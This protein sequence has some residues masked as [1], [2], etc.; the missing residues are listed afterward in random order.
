MASDVERVAL[1]AVSASDFMLRMIEQLDGENLVE[2]AM[3]VWRLWKDRNNKV[4]NGRTVEARS[5]VFFTQKFYA[6]WA[7]LRGQASSAPRV[8]FCPAWHRPPVGCIKLNVDGAFFANTHEMWFG[9]VL[10]DSHGRHICSR[11]LLLPELYSS[12]EGEAIGLFEALSWIKS[13]I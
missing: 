11:S 6:D 13:W 4:W 3:V 1:E 5:T 2:F 7:G 10:Y 9:L 8:C 12:E